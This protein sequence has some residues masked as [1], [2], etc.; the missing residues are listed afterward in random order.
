MT[1][2]E[3]LT[4]QWNDTSEFNRIEMIE[5]AKQFAEIKCKEQ[6]QIC[7][8]KFSESYHNVFVL[9]RDVSINSEIL[10]APTPDL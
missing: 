2:K 7:E 3:Y 6:R 8:E 5:F 1:A 4:L 10:N 9:D